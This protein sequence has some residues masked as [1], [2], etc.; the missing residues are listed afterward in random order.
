MSGGSDR[1][2]CSAQGFGD[3][4]NMLSELFNNQFF[5][6]SLYAAFLSSIAIGIVGT[7]VY[8]RRITFISGGIAHSSYGGIGMSY[9]YGFHPMIGALGFALLTAIFISSLRRKKRKNEDML[10]SIAWA[11]GMSIGVLFINFTPGYVPNLMGYLFGNIITVPTSEI[12][13]ILGA[14]V[15][16]IILV[17]MLYKQFKAVTFDEEFAASMGIKTGLID[18]LLLCLIALS[19]IIL[20]KIVGIVLLIA[21]FSIPQAISLKLSKSFSSMM[22]F[23]ALFGLAFILIGLFSSYYL[24]LASGSLTILIASLCYLA[25]EYFIKE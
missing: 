3:S 15:V 17:S 6:N 2:W 14:D 8:L 16:I 7:F 24:N 23:S 25:S 12:Y 20:I 4:L 10:I 21:L 11:L 22:F 5:I 13:F 18:M 1:S 19:T 9:Y